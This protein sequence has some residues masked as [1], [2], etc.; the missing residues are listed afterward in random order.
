MSDPPFGLVYASMQPLVPSVN[1][2]REVDE[3]QPCV[4]VEMRL[5]ENDEVEQHAD[6]AGGP[7]PDVFPDGQPDIRQSEN[8]GGRFQQ[9]H[10]GDSKQNER[11]P[12]VRSRRTS[13]PATV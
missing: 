8:D 5:P 2:K 9:G 13:G 10:G 7:R 4:K 12:Q 3:L 6:D 1:G 11:G